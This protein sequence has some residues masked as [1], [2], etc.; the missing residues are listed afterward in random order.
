[1]ESLGFAV[2]CFTA[3]PSC[4]WSDFRMRTRSGRGPPARGCAPEAARLMVTINEESLA[5]R[6]PFDKAR[7][8]A[9]RL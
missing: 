8:T 1:M 3:S 6:R 9:K 7:Q 2:A 5:L 4:R